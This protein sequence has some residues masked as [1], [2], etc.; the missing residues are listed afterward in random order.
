MNK[1]KEDII[2]GTY[3]CIGNINYILS[4]RRKFEYEWLCVISG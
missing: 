4:N 2:K 3:E 1:F